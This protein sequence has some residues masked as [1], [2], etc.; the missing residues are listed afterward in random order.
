MTLKGQ[1]QSLTS[2]QVRSMSRGDRNGSFCTSVDLPGRDERT[3]TNPTCLTLLDQKLLVNGSW[4]V[5][6]IETIHEVVFLFRFQHIVQKVMEHVCTYRWQQVKLRSE[7]SRSPHLLRKFSLKNIERR[8]S[9]RGEGQ[10]IPTLS[11][12]V[13]KMPLT[14]GQTPTR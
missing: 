10:G 12:T 14:G 2:G 13:W 5:Q 1:G 9:V 3:D 8:H 11:G 7:R 6:F 4:W